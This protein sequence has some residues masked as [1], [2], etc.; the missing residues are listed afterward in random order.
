MRRSALLM[1][2]GLV[3]LL[4]LAGCS[5]KE[6]KKQSHF[7]QGKE[8]FDKGEFKAAKIELKNAIQ[9]DPKFA[10][11]YYL[12]GMVEYGNMNL[13]AC[14]ESLVKYLEL[15]PKGRK[16]AEVKEMLNDPS[17]KKLK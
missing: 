6:D 2:I 12:L 3:I 4:A 1:G 11:S 10:E 14:K 5:S 9:I 15:D 16:A 13:K 17:L 8:Y 7:T